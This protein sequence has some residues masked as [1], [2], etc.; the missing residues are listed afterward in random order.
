MSIKYNKSFCTIVRSMNSNKLT[1]LLNQFGLT[2]RIVHNMSDVQIIMGKP[3]NYDKVNRI[4]S[5][6]T[7]RSIEY[8]RNNL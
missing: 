1:Y 6:E 7:Q 3:I 5:D 4:I 8:L 2:D